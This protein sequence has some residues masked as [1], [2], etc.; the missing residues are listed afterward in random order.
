MDGH[1][2]EL[3]LP[4]ENT[5]LS[6][7][8]VSLQ[9]TL[10]ES[11]QKKMIHGWQVIG[12]RKNDKKE[13]GAALLYLNDYKFSDK[14]SMMNMFGFRRTAFN[15]NGE[16]IGLANNSLFYSHSRR[17]SLGIELNSELTERSY[18]YRL[19]PQIQYAFS[20]NSVIQFGGGPSQLNEEKRTEWLVTSRLVHDF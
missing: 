20:K 15:K 5:T 12:Q 18:Q 16:F 9:G 14:W 7:Y 6:Q 3:E 2:I 13:Y 4:V 11:L 19:T 8:K 17:F 1:A 10:G